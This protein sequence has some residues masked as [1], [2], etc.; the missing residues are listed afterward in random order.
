MAYDPIRE[1]EEFEL[2]RE[3]L[4]LAVTTET[5]QDSASTPTRSRSFRSLRRTI[6]GHRPDR[7]PPRTG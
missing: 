3:A 6:S 7:T 4:R 5:L 1:T 2:W